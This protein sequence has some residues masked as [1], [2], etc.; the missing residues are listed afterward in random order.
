MLSDPL[1]ISVVTP[2][3]NV[4]PYLREAIESVLHQTYTC[5]EFLLAD[6]GSTDG[7]SEIVREYE[8]KYPGKIR[9]L[10]HPGC[11]HRGT[12]ATRLLAVKN[13]GSGYIAFLDAD[14]CWYQGKLAFQ[15][16]IIKR[17][18]QASMICGATEYWYSWA[19]DQKQDE[20]IAVGGI[21]N[22]L[23]LPP[24]AALEL[25]PLGKGAAPCLGS[26]VLKKEAAMQYENLDLHF[27]GKY[28]LYEDQAFLIKIYL[29]GSIFI[30]S[31]VWDKYRQ[32]PDSNMHSL[33]GRGYYDEVRYYFLIWLRNYLKENE[34][35]DPFIGRK[36]KGALLPYQSP[37]W[38]KI[39][40][41]LKLT[42]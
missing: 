42:I 19:G 11:E 40:R 4:A 37:L 28:Q 41:K 2:F 8:K 23:M 31:E 21:Q 36:L 22:E 10:C 1:L 33:T 7:S 13:A 26:M 24:K 16:D 14:D 12:V 5:W 32:R 38:Y 9:Y 25:Y 27:S 3:Y 35:K 6:D 18:P 29:S 34:I 17:Y 30:S 39:K 15:M 20:I